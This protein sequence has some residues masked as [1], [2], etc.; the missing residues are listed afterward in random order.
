MKKSKQ[1]NPNRYNFRAPSFNFY[2][3]YN[4]ISFW[5]DRDYE[6]Q[7]D[8]M[9][10]S[11]LLNIARKNGACSKLIDIGAGPGRMAPLYELFCKKFI[12]LD[13]SIDQL[14]EAKKRIKNRKK[15]EI[16][17]ADGQDIP[18]PDASCD[19]VVSIRVFHYI[20]NPQEILQEAKRILK[21]EGYLIIEI[22]N[23]LH[24]KNR[25]RSIFSKSNSNISMN[26]GDKNKTEKKNFVFVN[27]NPKDIAALLKVDGFEIIKVLSVSN[28]RIPLIKKIFPNSFLLFFE[29]NM[30]TKLAPLWF[31]P[32]IYF[33]AKKRSQ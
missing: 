28:F 21:P 30:Q 25:I 33:L 31:G 17:L 23:K 6:N 15:A 2:D 1:N 29:K 8:K 14:E 27:H 18:L 11:Q 24:I 3:D 7:S 4:Y 32:S 12:L 19:T 16:I 22:P 26:H 20:S 9:A 13:P 10:L 5:Q